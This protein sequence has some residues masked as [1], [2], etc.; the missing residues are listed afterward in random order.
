VVSVAYSPN[1]AR[2]ASG[3]A[4]GTVKIW[5]V[6]TGGELKTLSGYSTHIKSRLVYS[7]DGVFLAAAMDNNTISIFS[8][9]TGGETRVLRGHTGAVYDLAYNP[10]GRHL[11]SA[12]LDGTTRVWDI[13]TGRELV[14]SIGFSNGEW[15]T[16]TPDGYYAASVWG[17]RYFNI[18]VGSDV[19]GLELYR[20]AFYNPYLVHSRLQ[21]RKIRNDRSLRNINTFGAPP[22]L[23]IASPANSSYL[24]SAMAELSASA[25]D[26]NFPLQSFRIYLNDRL[27]GADLMGGLVGAGLKPT[28]TGIAAAGRLR[29]ASFQLPLEL[30]PGTNRIEVTVSNGS[31]EGRAAVTVE[32]PRYLSRS[33]G[34]ILPNLRI[35]SIGISRY[36]DPR[37]DHLG[38][39]VFDAREIINAFKDQEGKLYG[40][41]TSLLIATGELQF[42]TKNNILREL[43][44]FFQGLSSRDTALVFLSGHGVNDDDGNYF[45]L[46]ADIRL[47]S[48]GGIPF[49][50]ALSAE[51]LVAALDMP[52]RKLLFIDTSHTPGISALNIQPVDVN[53][54]ATD[55]R[56]FRPLI[57]TAG[58]GDELSTENVEYKAGL[59]SYAIKEGL[60]G[61]ADSN[62]NRIITMQELD[63]Y[64]SGRVPDLSGGRQHPS[65]HSFDGYVDFDLLSIE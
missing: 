26:R 44:A 15:I 36:D 48:G 32:T 21:G 40:T 47:N 30:D 2:I 35:L 34:Q 14:Q 23:S 16:I 62:G 60:G 24:N 46:P 49:Q 51:D 61:K 54:L 50:D 29:E 59:F 12:S 6:E 20:S 5:D 42:P 1:G 55:L 9:E 53:R 45:F 52:G 57:F 25:A 11:V 22:T 58:R 28:A 10:N 18:R 43:S 4:D 37:I 38:F 33:Q 39:A 65:T 13:A 19:Y 41:V 63:T 27:I 17:D 31:A 8:A 3:S 7:S 56:S 64:V